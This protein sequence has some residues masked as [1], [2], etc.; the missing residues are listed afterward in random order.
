MN[1]LITLLLVL[2]SL[3]SFA[4]ETELDSVPLNE[5]PEQNKKISRPKKRLFSVAA[6]IENALGMNPG[7]AAYYS[8]PKNPWNIGLKYRHISTTVSDI[9]LNGAFIGFEAQRYLW[10]SGRLQLW[11]SGEVGVINT[12]MD[13]S[14]FSS[15]ESKVKKTEPYFALGADLRYNLTSRLRATAGLS[16]FQDSLNKNFEGNTGTYRL[17]TKPFHLGYR[18]G[19][20]YFL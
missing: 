12:D 6:T 20:L 14:Y 2:S 8:F 1:K 7:F 19:L 10:H 9:K 17:E 13:L 18:A 15:T 5:L 4:Q 16:V 3:P 11:G